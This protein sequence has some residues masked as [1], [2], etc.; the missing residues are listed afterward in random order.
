MALQDIQTKLNTTEKKPLKNNDIC[1]NDVPKAATFKS[2]S[3]KKDG[4]RTKLIHIDVAQQINT[5]KNFFQTAGARLSKPQPKDNLEAK[6]LLQP[7]KFD[8]PNIYPSTVKNSTRSL[9]Q[10]EHENQRKRNALLN[11][12]AMIG[13]TEA[14]DRILGGGNLNNL[15]LGKGSI[16]DETRHRLNF[17]LEDPRKMNLNGKQPV[18]IPQLINTE[19]HKK[20]ENFQLPDVSQV[21]VSM[22]KKTSSSKETSKGLNAPSNIPMADIKL[23]PTELVR[24][25]RQ[26]NDKDMQIRASDT[27]ISSLKGY[28]EALRLEN[29]NLRDTNQLHE[30]HISQLDRLLAEK[31]I[32]RQQ[33]LSM[34]NENSLNIDNDKPE[35][36][37]VASEELT[38]LYASLTSLGNECRTLRSQL[39]IM[40]SDN[41]YLK[42]EAR[43][44]EIQ[45]H[46]HRNRILRELS[47]LRNNLYWMTTDNVSDQLLI[48]MRFIGGK[49]DFNEKQQ[50]DRTMGEW[51][52]LELTLKYELL[53]L[54]DKWKDLTFMVEYLKQELYQAQMGRQR[55]IHYLLTT[56]TA[57]KLQV[58][59]MERQLSI[60]Y[61]ASYDPRRRLRAA[62]WVVVATVRLRNTAVKTWRSQN[63]LERYRQDWVDNA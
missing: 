41:E 26:I 8:Q 37:N 45:D 50:D 13:K 10:I 40:N 61:Q 22:M 63:T 34:V 62:I 19:S 3:E 11:N 25:E 1:V 17:E 57:T 49:S 52:L 36:T 35:M 58:D 28:I 39:T 9:E 59:T 47:K 27:E 33:E 51:H 5:M 30:I 48:V 29:Q 54:S 16:E 31:E 2:V 24:L 46:Q 6:P 20:L 15:Q 23:K 38:Q 56:H 42:H 60:P 14:I 32:T 4:E 12:L 53:R 7:A 43:T 55:I 21:S 44:L 18:Q